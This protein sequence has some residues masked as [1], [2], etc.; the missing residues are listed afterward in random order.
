MKMV[1]LQRQ[2]GDRS[3]AVVATV[4]PMQ[5]AEADTYAARLLHL[6]E[7]HTD[8]GFSV[9]TTPV[10][11]TSGEAAEPPAAPDELLRAVMARD[12]DTGDG[13]HDLPEPAPHS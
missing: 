7:Q 6:A 9:S 3:A 8:L 10:E 4:G 5:D 13:D 11:S 12:D 2:A 1:K